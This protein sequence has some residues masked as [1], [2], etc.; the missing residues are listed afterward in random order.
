M[1]LLLITKLKMYLEKNGKKTG[2]KVGNWIRKRNNKEALK[3]LWLE[4][5][6]FYSYK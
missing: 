1:K 3:K 6:R 4:I 2:R 5:F